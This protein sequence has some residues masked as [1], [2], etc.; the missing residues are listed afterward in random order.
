M[1]KVLTIIA[2]LFSCNVFAQT[3]NVTITPQARDIEYIAAFIYNDNSVEDLYD[4]L[5]AK[6][7]VVT[8][9]T[10]NTTVS[11]TATSLD[12]F[13]TFQRLKTDHIALKAS[14]TGRIEALLRAANVAYLTTKLNELD[15]TDLNNFQ[16]FRTFGRTR[17]RRTNN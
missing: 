2:I 17:L 7:R 15:V 11:I 6:F 9:P 16:S 10:G 14:C 1:K 4:S 3:E 5:K 12:W 13:V 8:P